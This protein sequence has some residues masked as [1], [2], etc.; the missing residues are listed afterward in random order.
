MTTQTKEI[1]STELSDEKF[2]V[3]ESQSYG[4]EHY[5]K[6][7]IF[8]GSKLIMT[9]G[10]KDMFEE[11][12]CFWVGDVI[13]SYFKEMI[14]S[15]EEFLVARVIKNLNDNSCEFELSDGNDK[16]II[17]QKIPY[18]DLTMN[19]KIFIQFDGERF[20]VMCPSEY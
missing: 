2:G 11:L 4:T 13:A 10:I 8:T 18:T 17:I 20:V 16:K 19:L 9:D 6:M 12:S 3:Y 5:Y 14:K 15:K 1:T 7:N